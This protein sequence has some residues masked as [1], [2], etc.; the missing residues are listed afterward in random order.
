[1]ITFNI[2]MKNKMFNTVL[3]TK[4]LKFGVVFDAVKH[5]FTFR[6]LFL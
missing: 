4:K 2:N 6:N 1:M 3:K 5:L